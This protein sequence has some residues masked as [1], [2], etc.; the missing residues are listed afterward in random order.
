MSFQYLYSHI[1]HRKQ[2]KKTEKEEDSTKT[3]TITFYFPKDGERASLFTSFRGSVAVE[4]ALVLP[5]FFFAVCCICYLLEI[6][7][8]QMDVRAATD[9]VSR[10]IA[11]EVYSIPAVRPAKVKADVV[12][13]IGKERLDG[14]IVEGGSEG[15]DFSGTIVSAK[16]GVIHMNVKYEVILPFSMFGKL[17]LSFQEKFS[18]KG[19]TGYVGDGFASGREEM[20]YITDN[21]IVYHRDS[22]CT[23]LDLSIQMVDKNAVGDMRNEGH[24]KYYPCERCG[25]E[26]GSRVYIT[27]QGNRYHSTLG[28]SGLKRSVYAVPISEV[29][30]KGVCSR[31]GY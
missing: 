20:V 26:I 13:L 19:W 10:E 9:S 1:T 14:S 31:C 11:K 18:V 27:R 12:E 28:C 24:E 23:Y 15:L 29:Q 22:H 16:N 7:S 5:I 30:G 6:M 2:K 21:G 25:G 8:L 17:T 4:A 3:Q